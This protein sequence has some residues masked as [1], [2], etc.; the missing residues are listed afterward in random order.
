VVPLLLAYAVIATL[1]WLRPGAL[2]V[3]LV[4]ALTALGPLLPV[5]F[6][7]G[8]AL[9]AAYLDPMVDWLESHPSEAANPIYTN[10]QLLAPF[11]Y[12]RGHP[13]YKNVSFVVSSE[14]IHELL[15]LTNA[16]NGQRERILRLGMENLYGK[17]VVGPVTP[18]ALPGGS[19]LALRLENRLPLLFPDE[20]WAPRLEVL[21]ES[22]R[23]RIARLRPDTAP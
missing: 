7:V 3:M 5:R 19:L 10:S 17:S 1:A 2:A 20:V 4:T 22:P 6:E 16:D 23:F 9:T 18:D 11:L 14:M 13:A 8:R 12:A 15:F 21:A